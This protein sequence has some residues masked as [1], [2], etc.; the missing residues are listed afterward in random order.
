MVKTFVI[1]T[2]DI[3]TAI[4]TTIIIIVFVIIMPCFPTD[5]CLRARIVGHYPLSAHCYAH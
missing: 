4:I 3:I 5:P 1:I 2:N